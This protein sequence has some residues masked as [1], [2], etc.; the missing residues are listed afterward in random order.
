MNSLIYFSSYEFMMIW[1]QYHSNVFYAGAKRECI[2]IAV[3][4]QCVHH[5]PEQKVNFDKCPLF[6]SVVHTYSAQRPAE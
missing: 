6:S 2:V 5:L 4:L 1:K 3:S